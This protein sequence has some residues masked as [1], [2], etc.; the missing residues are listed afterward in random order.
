MRITISGHIGSGKTTVSKILSGLT[1]FS[2]YSGGF[3]FRKISEEQGISLEEMNFMAEKDSKLDFELNSL[4]EKFLMEHNNII[5]E[6]RLSGWIAYSANIDAYKVF[7]DASRNT[8][9]DRVN[10]RESLSNIAE[11]V[12]SREISENY[13]FKEYFNFDMNDKSIYDVVM[14]TEKGSAD[15][16]ANQ[17][18]RMALSHA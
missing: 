6:S 7:L 8:R 11:K 10:K 9:I 1:N 17:I 3:F 12:I 5:V 18:Y 14:D 13:R 15:E 2:V 4:I 16:I